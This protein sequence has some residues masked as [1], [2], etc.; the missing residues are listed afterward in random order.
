MF[1]PFGPATF[2]DMTLML[3]NAPLAWLISAAGTVFNQRVL[4]LDLEWQIAIMVRSRCAPSRPIPCKR[5]AKTSEL[6]P[7]EQKSSFQSQ[8]F[9]CRVIDRNARFR[10][11]HFVQ[12]LPAA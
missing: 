12:R 9:D 11:F 1:L 8:N 2:V 3:C 5:P 7:H 6:T 10:P 4:G